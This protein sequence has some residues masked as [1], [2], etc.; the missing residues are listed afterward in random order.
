V[1]HNGRNFAITLKTNRGKSR[2]F[3]QKPVNIEEWLNVCSTKAAYTEN[4]SYMH[5]CANIKRFKE[6]H[7]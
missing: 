3:N 5:A 7:P 2:S 1:L 6:N 4:I